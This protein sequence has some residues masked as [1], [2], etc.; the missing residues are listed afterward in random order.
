VCVVDMLRQS[1]SCSEEGRLR[2]SAE[3]SKKPATVATPATSS[4]FAR[5]SNE[6]WLIANPRL[7]NLVPQWPPQA[8]D[9]YQ[10]A[11][12]SDTARGQLCRPSETV[13][14]LLPMPQR[15]EFRKEDGELVVDSGRNRVS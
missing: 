11:D 6:L 13:L 4:D 8:S 1:F 2:S 10:S 12:R 14:E 3:L 15:G 9:P 5:R 7:A